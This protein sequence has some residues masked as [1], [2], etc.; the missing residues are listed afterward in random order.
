MEKQYNSKAKKLLNKY[1]EKENQLKSDF[2]N[3]RSLMKKN[4]DLLKDE[5]E[6][7]KKD[8]SKYKIEIES[9]KTQIDTKNFETNSILSN[10]SRK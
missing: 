3:E 7:L 5:N 8:I 2:N 4:Y 9:L 6:S 10:K 1:T